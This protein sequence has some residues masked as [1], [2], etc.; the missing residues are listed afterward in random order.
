MKQDNVRQDKAGK[1]RKYQKLPMKKH[2]PMGRMR[3]RIDYFPPP[4]C[5][6]QIWT[7]K[8]GENKISYGKMKQDR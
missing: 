7:S 5:A 6:R 1:S 4:R 8:I 2:V 3:D